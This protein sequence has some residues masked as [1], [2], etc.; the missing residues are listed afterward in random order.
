M[1][2]TRELRSYLFP[3]NFGFT[4]GLGG[5]TSSFFDLLNDPTFRESIGIPLEG[6]DVFKRQDL[7]PALGEIFDF[8]K[9]TFTE[10]FL[11]AGPKEGRIFEGQADKIQKALDTLDDYKDA[12]TVLDKYQRM[13]LERALERAKEGEKISR[14]G[15]NPLQLKMGLVNPVQQSGVAGFPEFQVANLN[16][17]QPTYTDTGIASV[18]PTQVST[19][20]LAT[21][22]RQEQAAASQRAQNAAKAQESRNQSR[23][24]YTGGGGTVVIGKGGG[25]SKVVSPR[26]REAMYS[27]TPQRSS[28]RGPDLR[29]RANGGIVTLFRRF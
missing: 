29:R 3:D 1:A 8:D 13:L 4:E 6:G 21:Q 28:S 15:L 19:P 23:D 27:P 18:F 5:K 9:G 10:D 11:K 25:E 2:T 22:I 24:D 20:D 12:G 14:L 16:F 26:S 7:K 17:G